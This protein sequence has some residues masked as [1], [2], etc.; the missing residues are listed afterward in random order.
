MKSRAELLGN[1][2]PAL[3]VGRRANGRASGPHLLRRLADDLPTR[4]H[5]AVR[6]MAA[7]LDPPIQSG[8]GTC[9]SLGENEASFMA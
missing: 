2:W 6:R 9:T 1:E 4:A 3:G 5:L 7:R 8:R